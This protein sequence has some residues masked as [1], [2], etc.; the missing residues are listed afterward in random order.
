MAFATLYLLSQAKLNNPANPPTTPYSS[1]TF[2]SIHKTS[3]QTEQ[4]IGYPL[5][6]NQGNL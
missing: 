4:L 2:V 3:L 6:S 5:V 1:V